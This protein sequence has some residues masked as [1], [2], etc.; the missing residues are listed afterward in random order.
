MTRRARNE[1]E[2]NSLEGQRKRLEVKTHGKDIDSDS[3]TREDGDPE[4]RE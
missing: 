3:G 4:K 2:Q 1:D